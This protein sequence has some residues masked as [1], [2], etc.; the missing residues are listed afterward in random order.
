MVTFVPTILIK[1]K[2]LGVLSSVNTCEVITCKCLGPDSQLSKVKL[3]KMSFN[4]N[5]SQLT[6]IPLT[7][8]IWLEAHFY[9]V[10][11]LTG[12]RPIATSPGSVFPTVSRAPAEL[13][14]DSAKSP[15]KGELSSAYALLTV[16]NQTTK[17]GPWNTVSWAELEWNRAQESALVY[18]TH[19][20]LICSVNGEFFWT[21]KA[22]GLLEN[23]SPT[24]ARSH[25][26]PASYFKTGAMCR[27][28]KSLSDRTWKMDDNRMV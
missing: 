17:T 12:L 1:S 26:K 25:R 14:W 16:E 7:A 4:L 20:L 27:N 22:K 23:W 8:W 15:D 11:S 3:N 28:A 19:R 10:F 13:N 5:S 24:T 21:A 6:Q 9:F 2:T 18:L